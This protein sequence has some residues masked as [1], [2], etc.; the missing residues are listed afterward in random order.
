MTKCIGCG[1]ILQDK[2][3]NKEGYTRSLDNK[4]CERCFNIKHYNKYLKVDDKDYSGVIK[5]I[6]KHGD[7]ILLVTD[8]LNLYNLDEL[9]L[10]SP[11]ILVL[12]KTDLLPRSINKEHL[13]SNIK[14]NVLAKIMVSSK[15]NYNFDLLYELI[16]KYKKGNNV[17][18]I[19]YTNAGKSSLINKFLKN[20]GS[21]E[22]A[23]TVSN[24]P[25]T[26]L[27]LIENKVN[28]KL[29]LIDTPGLL[30]KGSMILSASS[31]MLKKITPKKEVRP[32][33][34]QIK[35]FQSLLIEDFMRI[36]MENTNVICYM[37]NALDFRRVYNKKNCNLSCYDIDMRKNQD[38]V[39]KGLGF[40]TFKKN[41]HITLWLL[42]GISYLIRDSII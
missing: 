25:S 30:D 10:N 33:S 42:D 31:L 27:D 26:T 1:V 17:Y 36:D 24:L 4:F 12:T 35:D 14:L 23:I 37:S 7:L 28:D 2:F 20:Y 16:M 38:L 3:P 21:F 22:G 19:G 15:N 41:C 32:I 40:I 5:D 9:K 29:T 18:V 11:V 34:Y 8:F 6:D 13:L 39:I